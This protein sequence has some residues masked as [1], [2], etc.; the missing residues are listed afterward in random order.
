M[1]TRTQTAVLTLAGATAAAVLLAGCTGSSG[2]DGSQTPAS[3]STPSATAASPTPSVAPSVSATSPSPSFSVS[4]GSEADITFAQ[5]M[6]PHHEQAVEMADMA[7]EQASTPEV[8]QLA[9]EIKGA[10]DPEIKLMRSWL[11]AWGAPEEMEGMDG[12]DHG[13]MDMGGQSAGGMMSDE[14]M[15]GLMEAQGVEF[16]RMWLEMMIEHHEGAIE[17]AKAVKEQSQNPE[18]LALADAII[19]AQEAEIAV[20]EQLLAQ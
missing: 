3:P 7:L 20:M 8:R 16:D 1:P 14:D 18:V 15:S 13:G 2:A 19:S 17:M 12:M 9:Q 10:Q 4:P 11:K 6:I 5:L